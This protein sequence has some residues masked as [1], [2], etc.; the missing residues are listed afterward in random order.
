MKKII[1]II[2]SILT[3]FTSAIPAF[4]AETINNSVEIEKKD[5]TVQQTFTAYST[6][7]FNYNFEK[8][9]EK[10]GKKY[11]LKGVNYS[12]T[13]TKDVKQTQN[14]T[15]KVDYKNL[16]SKEDITPPETLSI[17]QDGQEIEVK[18]TDINYTDTTITNRSERLTAYTDYDYKTVKPVPPETKTINYFDE[19]SKQNVKATLKFK[20]LKAVDDWAWRNDVTIPITFSFYDSEYYVLGDKYIPYDDNTP[21]LKGY[22]NDLLEELGLDTYKYRINSVEWSGEKYQVGDVTYRKA[23]AHGERYA[24]NY[25]AYYESKVNLPNAKGYNAVANYDTEIS[26]V[27]GEKE[28]TVLATAVYKPNN[29]TAQIIA[30]VFGGLLVIVLLVIAILYIISKKN[31]KKGGSPDV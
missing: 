10:D 17:M 5:I 26:V 13:E 1:P 30:G 20:E 7:D 15:H 16:Y 28:Y 23:I 9:I 4:A 31:D 19:A 3:L 11:D 27:S 6:D 8:Q 12:V 29:T 18:L 21:A 2:L 25:V 22:E 24:A 14:V